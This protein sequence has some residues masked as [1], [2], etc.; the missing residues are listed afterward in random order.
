VRL[1]DPQGGCVIWIDLGHQYSGS[2]LF[3]L[4]IANGISITPGVL[5]SAGTQ[6]E[7]CIRMSYGLVWNRDVE[8]AIVLLSELLPSAKK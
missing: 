8:Q 1:S 6:Y 7:S 4:A 2:K 3:Q 5:F